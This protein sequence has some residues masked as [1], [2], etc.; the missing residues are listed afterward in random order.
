MERRP[1]I[2]FLFTDM[3]RADTFVSLAGAPTA[4]YD[5]LPLHEV[6]AGRHERPFVFSQHDRAEK[7]QYLLASRDWTFFYSAADDG[8][9]LQDH[10]WARTEIPGYSD[11]SA[12]G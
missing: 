1:N 8:L 7:A 4:G 10:P 6:A 5:G 12:R 11:Q 9:L 2:L 3:Q